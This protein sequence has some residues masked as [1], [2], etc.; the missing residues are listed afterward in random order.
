MNRFFYSAIILISIAGCSSSSQPRQTEINASPTIATNSPAN[1]VIVSSANQSNGNIESAAPNGNVTIQN[2]A[3]SKENLDNMRKKPGARLGGA[4]PMPNTIP[5]TVAAPDNST[6]V[7]AMNAKGLP[8][9]TRTFKKHP[10]LMKIERTDLNNS[11][12]KV[13]LKNGKVVNLPE[14]LA[15]DFLTA[16]ASDILK[17]VGVASKE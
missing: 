12:I 15:N 1:R 16:S 3:V 5:G 13:Y 17:A 10:L 6:I 8:I 2:F 4:Q 14:N 9:E 11:D 7:S